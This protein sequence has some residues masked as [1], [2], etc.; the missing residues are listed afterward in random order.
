LLYRKDL[1]QDGW[2]PLYLVVTLVATLSA[3]VP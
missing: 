3:P 2:L 1:R